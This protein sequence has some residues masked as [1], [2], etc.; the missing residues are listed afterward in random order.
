MENDMSILMMNKTSE[1]LK[2][3]FADYKQGE[4]GELEPMVVGFSGNE[5]QVKALAAIDWQGVSLLSGDGTSAEMVAVDEV[6]IDGGNVVICA[7]SVI[8]AEHRS[9]TIESLVYISTG[10]KEH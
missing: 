3:W 10:G 6:L 7:H 4:V 1:T 2:A 9:E 8:P 5:E